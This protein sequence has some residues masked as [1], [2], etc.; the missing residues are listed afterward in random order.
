MSRRIC[1]L[2]PWISSRVKRRYDAG[3]LFGLGGVDFDQPGMSHRTSE[4]PRMSHARKLDIAGVNRFAGN[5]FDG[6][7]AMRIGAGDL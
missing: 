4:N 1:K 6:V 2:K 5:F 7:D 3:K